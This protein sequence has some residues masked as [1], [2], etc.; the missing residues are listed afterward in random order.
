MT[1]E[2]FERK[3][4]FIVEHQAQ[5]A[6]DIQKLYEAQARTEQAQAR[7]DRALSR[8]EQALSRTEQSL[9]R[10]EQAVA[11]TVQAVAETQQVVTRLANVTSVGFKDVNGK[12][13]ALVDSEIRLTESQ[14]LLTE[15]QSRFTESQSRT[16]E[17]LKDLAARVDALLVL[18]G[19]YFRKGGNGKSGR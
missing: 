4:E 2:E 17:N 18:M 10:T 7:T 11:Q 1:N 9:S 16:D 3:M 13:D 19:R 8:T 14:S 12:I 15:S 6:S 5:F